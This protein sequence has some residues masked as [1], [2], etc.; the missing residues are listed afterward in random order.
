MIG[1][2][3]S[4]VLLIGSIGLMAGAIAHNQIAPSYDT[5]L[6]VA[7]ANVVS[8][9]IALLAL[10]IAFPAYRKDRRARLAKGAMFLGLVW[11]AGLAVLVP[12]SDSGLLSRVQ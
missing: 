1:T 8:L 12:L 4:L 11:A 10:A 9:I 2:V 7:V 3:A 6:T 5:A